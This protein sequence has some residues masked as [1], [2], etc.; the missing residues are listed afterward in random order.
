MP[1]LSEP[2]IR[3]FSIETVARATCTLNL[4]FLSWRRKVNAGQFFQVIITD[5][6]LLHATMW[7]FVYSQTHWQEQP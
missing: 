2:Q 1:C 6:L 7:R 4:A 3:D 5:E